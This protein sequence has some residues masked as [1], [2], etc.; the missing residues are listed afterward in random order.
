M[1]DGL[2]SAMQLF[3]IYIYAFNIHYPKQLKKRGAKANLLKNNRIILN[4]TS[5][6]L[7]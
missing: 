5:V 7:V 1:L 4:K 3:I 2:G 6:Y